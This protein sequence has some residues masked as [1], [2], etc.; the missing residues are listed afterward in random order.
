MISDGLSNGAG[1]IF[2]KLQQIPLNKMASGIAWIK[3]GDSIAAHCYK[4]KTG[5]WFRQTSADIGPPSC[6][7]PDNS[8]LT[9]ARRWK[10][11][12][13]SLLSDLQRP[14]PYSVDRVT[15]LTSWLS[16]SPVPAEAHIH[17]MSLSRVQ[18]LNSP[19]VLNLAKDTINASCDVQHEIAKLRSERK[20][21]NRT[22]LNAF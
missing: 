11:Y 5:S 12:A 14:R 16:A 20:L 19:F 13:N 7:C 22:L 8:R 10:Y 4:F 1:G 6:L 21:L 15:L 17:Y 3:F 18:T 2:R 9:E